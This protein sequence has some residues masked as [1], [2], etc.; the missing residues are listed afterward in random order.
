MAKLWNIVT[1]VIV[2]NKLPLKYLFESNFFAASAASDGNS[3]I[4]PPIPGELPRVRLRLIGFSSRN[5]TRHHHYHY[6]MTTQDPMQEVLHRCSKT[7]S[8]LSPAPALMRK[9]AQENNHL[10]TRTPT[11]PYA[12][13]VVEFH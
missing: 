10:H 11:Y 6:Q 1:S 7:A 5:V 3:D 8:V 4:L 2:N 12:Y 9:K 13:A